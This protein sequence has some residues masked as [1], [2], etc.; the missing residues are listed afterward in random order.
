MHGAQEKLGILLVNLG[1]PD[2]PTSSAVRK[3]LA[4]FLSDPRVIEVN[5][6]LWW[7]IL[8][9]VILNVRP[10]AATSTAAIWSPSS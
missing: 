9:G 10:A 3:Y 6:L 8:N 5:R 1:S 2:A 4:Q 7:F